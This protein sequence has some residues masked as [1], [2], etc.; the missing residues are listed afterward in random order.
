M[1]RR[2]AAGPAAS[3][4]LGAD[5]DE[6]EGGWGGG[7][8]HPD[9]DGV[10]DEND[11]PEDPVSPG[12]GDVVETDNQDYVGRNQARAHPDW[13][14]NLQTETKSGQPA[15]STTTVNVSWGTPPLQIE[16]VYDPKKNTLTPEFAFTTSPNFSINQK[17]TTDP[18]S[19]SG[20]L[21]FGYGP[22]GF[23]ASL[24]GTT[25]QLGLGVGLPGYSQPLDAAVQNFS[26]NLLGPS[27]KSMGDDIIGPAIRGVGGLFESVGDFILDA[28]WD[29]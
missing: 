26:E 9:H 27:V 18:N 16:L 5:D 14:G 7:P 23:G 1:V 15:P 21:N 3:G 11:I 4:A 24:D 12:A 10:T 17:Q 19:T 22:V 8:S 2:R 29:N 20:S 28:Y 25:Q 6:E 13:S